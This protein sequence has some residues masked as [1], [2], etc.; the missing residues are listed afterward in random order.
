M[1]GRRNGSR[2]RRLRLAILAAA[3]ALSLGLV[4]PSAASASGGDDEPRLTVMTRN[5]YLG[6]S[7]APALT[8]TDPVSFLGAVAQIYGTAQ[9]TN[10]PARAEA[11]ADEIAAHHPDLVG[12]QEVTI[13]QTSGP[14]VPPSLDFLEVL[15]AALAARGLD[16]A[17]A[18]A[19]SNADIGPIPL[20]EPCASTIVG[21]C[22]VTLKDRD[23]ILV[24]ADRKGLT[25]GNPRTGAY[26]A[27]QTFT[28][29]VPGA[30]PVSFKRGWASVDG[31]VDGVRFH[32]A[33]THL[34]TE[35]FPAVQEA[36]AAEFLAG[37]ARGRGAAIAT[38]DFNSA[39]DGSTTTSYAQLTDRFRDA[40]RV[41][42]H[43]AGLTCCQNDTLSNPVSQLGS[44]IDLVLSRGD[45]KA[46]SARVVGATPFRAEPPLWPSDHAGVVATLRLDD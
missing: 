11:I 6:S 34:E 44:R 28:P 13:W 22:L 9:F 5:L 2:R 39:A 37:P 27:Q 35:D 8:A 23:V 25:W 14:G 20:V 7:L 38:G 12:L 16:Y 33:N 40:W 42:H 18:A 1:V 17:V 30:A 26:V 32:Y 43:D 24:R 31:R 21:A 29:P 3:T 36:Q 19:A 4:T 10:F 15:G 46:V 45:A 41:N